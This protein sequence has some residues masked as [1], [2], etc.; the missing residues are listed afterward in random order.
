MTK[1]EYKA[2]VTPDVVREI[3]QNYT[4]NQDNPRYVISVGGKIIAVGGKIFYDSREQAVKA[5]YN[6][7][8]W[9]ALSALWKTMHP[10]DPW[11][12]WRN[13]DR[14]TIWKAV[15]EVLTESYGFKITQV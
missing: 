1:E 15:K 11:G 6:S 8:H 12:W 4:L 14:Q 10:S 13:T 7:F 5:F 2:M 9:R 3:F